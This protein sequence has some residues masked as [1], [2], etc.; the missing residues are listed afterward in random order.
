[1]N[2]TTTAA[3]TINAEQELYVIPCQQGYT[4]LGFDVCVRWGNGIAAW[5]AENEV[6]SQ[7]IHERERGTLEAYSKYQALAQAGR[8]LNQKT[9]KRCPINLTPQLVG[10]EGKRVEV[11]DCYGE[12]RRFIVGRS[13]GWMPCHLEIKRK[14]STGG[15]AVTGAPFKS[16]RVVGKAR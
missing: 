5:L 15:S 3:V 4:C 6:A 8:E 14:D 9:G 11:V 10:L 2:T 1:M 16:V 12:T 7:S 13:T